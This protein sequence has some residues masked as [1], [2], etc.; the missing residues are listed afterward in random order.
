MLMLIYLLLPFAE[1]SY[2]K[3]VVIDG[4]TCLLVRK[5]FYSYKFEVSTSLFQINLLCIRFCYLPSVFLVVVYLCRTISYYRTFLILLDR[6]NTGRSS[7]II[8]GTLRSTTPQL[9]THL[10]KKKYFFKKT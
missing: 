6:K 9:A 4:E 10:Q 5:Y 2:R 8:L 7:Y 3:Q 1:D